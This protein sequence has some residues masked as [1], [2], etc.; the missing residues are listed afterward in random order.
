MCETKAVLVLLSLIS[1]VA[2]CFC[3]YQEHT[4]N[5]MGHHSKIKGQVSC[6]NDCKKYCLKRGECLCLVDETLKA[7]ILRGCMEENVVKSTCGGTRLGY[8]IRKD[9]S[10]LIQN[11]TRRKQFNV[12]VDTLQNI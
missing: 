2:A 9:E 8:N 5:K 11:R 12:K 6:K 1:L 3:L 7:A 10:F 4:E